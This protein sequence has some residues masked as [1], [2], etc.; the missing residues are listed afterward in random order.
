MTAL[1]VFLAGFRMSKRMTQLPPAIDVALD[2]VMWVRTGDPR[3]T[4]AEIGA[5]YGLHV[6]TWA[7]LVRG[8]ADIWEHLPEAVR[9]GRNN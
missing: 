5:T 7:Q 6:Y 3:L 8:V 1:I 2:H 4:A 9:R